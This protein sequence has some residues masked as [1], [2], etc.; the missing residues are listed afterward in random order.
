MRGFEALLRW[1]DPELGPVG[2]QEFI[3]LA[4]RTGQILELGGWVMREAARQAA[5]W[6]AEGVAAGPIAVNVS[7]AQLDAGVLTELVRGVLAETGLRPGRL[8][9]EVT[10]SALLRDELQAIDELDG[11]RRLGVGLALDDFGTGY[12]SLSYLRRLPIDTVKIDRSFVEQIEDSD[13]DHAL[14]GSIIAM[15]KILGLSIVAEG[16][17]TERQRD[18]LA[19]MDCDLVQGFWYSAPVPASQIEAAIAECHAPRKRRGD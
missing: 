8:E 16:V 14:L 11:L 4:E 13:S 19:E 12:S 3:P 5:R 17:E 10:E 6:D 18:L 1:H 2:P 7:G 9:L 15:A